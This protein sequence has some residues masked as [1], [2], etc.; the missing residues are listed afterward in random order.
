[1]VAKKVS[2]TSG[3]ANCRSKLQHLSVRHKAALPQLVLS[4][5]LGLISCQ[6]A[7]PS[8]ETGSDPAGDHEWLEIRLR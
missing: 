5:K 6:Q 8:T 1:V 3:F 7:R 2:G 4:D